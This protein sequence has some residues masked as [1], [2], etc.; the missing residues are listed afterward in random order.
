MELVLCFES[1]FLA[2]SLSTEPHENHSAAICPMTV[3]CSTVNLPLLFTEKYYMPIYLIYAV[4]S[5][6]HPNWSLLVTTS[7]QTSTVR[8]P[9]KLVLCFDVVFLLPSMS[10]GP[11]SAP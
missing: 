10:T 4:G 5:L 11:I 1:F 2:P 3:C 9:I 8:H 7:K 6:R